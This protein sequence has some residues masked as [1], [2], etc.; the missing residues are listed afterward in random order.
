MNEIRPDQTIT[1]I[2]SREFNHDPGQAK[3]AAKNGPV[4]ITD[5][6]RQTH[7]VLSIEAYQKL[8][9]APSN[10]ADLLSQKEGEYFEFDPPRLDGPSLK[11]A[12][13]D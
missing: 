12:D 13:F 2:S 7:V 5:R 4:F 11:P 6:G 9:G 10:I 3:R 1:T 8:S